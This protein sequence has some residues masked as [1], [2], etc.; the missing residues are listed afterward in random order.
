MPIIKMIVLIV[1]IVITS[2]VFPARYNSLFNLKDFKGL[3]TASN[4]IVCFSSKCMV[5]FYSK[6]CLVLLTLKGVGKDELVILFG[7]Y[8]NTLFP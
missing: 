7:N 2:S 3:N 8:R 6:S 1:V 4:E 5:C